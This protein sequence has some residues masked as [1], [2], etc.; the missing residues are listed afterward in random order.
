MTRNT[1][2]AAAFSGRPRGGRRIVGAI[3][4]GSVGLTSCGVV[5]AVRKVEHAVKGNMATIDTFTNKIKSSESTTFEATYLTTGS[6]PATV[7]YAVQ[8]PQGLTF[9]TTPSGASS[10][11]V[12]IIVN[13]S[14]E[15][16]CSAASGSG[17]PSGS[18]SCQKLGSADAAAQNQIFDLYTP[19]H[20]TTFLKDFSLA[21]GLAGDKVTSST[22]SVNGFSM[23]CVD[24][25][26]SGVPGTSTICTTA[27]GILGY[28]KVATDSTSFEIKSYSASPPA[29]LFQLP[30]GATI[31]TTPKTSS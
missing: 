21:A 29:S 27:Q 24:F 22:M 17:T 23:Q 11:T 30:P 2:R 25:N 10:S 4:L 3:V 19:A 12:H 16:S 18:V 6:A 26:A 1:D 14:G 5:S 20:W 9:E 31:T 7:V 28:V 15:Y 13:S 8:P